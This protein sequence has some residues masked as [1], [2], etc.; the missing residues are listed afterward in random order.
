MTEPDLTDK[1]LTCV[2]CGQMFIL[3]A[4]ERRYFAREQLSEPKN[5]PPCRQRHKEIKKHTY[6]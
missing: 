1:P 6:V 4:G 2:G 5:C 3:E